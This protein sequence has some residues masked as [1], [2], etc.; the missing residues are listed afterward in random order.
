V[1]ATYVK[2][3]V[4]YLELMG[5]KLTYCSSSTLSLYSVACTLV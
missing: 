5:V 2:L 1:H 3:H 4:L